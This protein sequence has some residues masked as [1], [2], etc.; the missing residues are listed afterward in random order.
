MNKEEITLIS[1]LLKEVDN[2]YK[3]RSL[4]L[5]FINMKKLN[6]EFEE[7]YIKENEN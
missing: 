3:Q 4:I 6:I 2:L 7:F 1:E 5:K